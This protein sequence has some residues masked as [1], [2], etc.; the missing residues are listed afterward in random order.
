[1]SFK[2]V[3]AE[4][5]ALPERERVSLVTTLLGTLPPPVADVSDEEVEKRERDMDTGGVEPIPHEEFV[6]RVSEERGW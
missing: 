1:M 6:R 5:L 4:A 3:T 2:E